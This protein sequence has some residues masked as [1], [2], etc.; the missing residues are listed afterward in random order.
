MGNPLRSGHTNQAP[1][2]TSG[3]GLEIRGIL[4][5]TVLHDA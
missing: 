1:R 4:I 5:T 3:T 2:I